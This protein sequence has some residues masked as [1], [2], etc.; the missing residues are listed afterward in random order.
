MGRRYLAFSL[1]ILDFGRKGKMP[2]LSDE[3]SQINP[4]RLSPLVSSSASSTF[5]RKIMK[6]KE[7][8]IEYHR[9]T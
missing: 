9:I 5:P 6:T 7:I 2:G 8:C 1:P 4:G 3:G